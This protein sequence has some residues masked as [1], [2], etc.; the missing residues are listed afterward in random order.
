[1]PGLGEVDFP[2][3][4]PKEQMEASIKRAL[5]T[6][7]TGANKE[8][9]A[10][11]NAV[12]ER[13]LANPSPDMGAAEFTKERQRSAIETPGFQRAKNALIPTLATTATMIPGI[14]TAAQS[15]I[16][17]G[18]TALNQALGNEPF[19][20]TEIGKS[21]AYPVLGSAV[22]GAA[23]GGIKALGKFVNPGA[24]RT[25]GVEAAI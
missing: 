4:T 13:E 22:V 19:S 3:G 7:Q 17:A 18:G 21:A 14:G 16:G 11:P 6:R 2:D 15:A 25:A 1:M 24:T 12:M 23:K 10:N 5:L 9:Q 20:L 8:L